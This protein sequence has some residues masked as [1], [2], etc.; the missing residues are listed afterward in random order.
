MGL[1]KS[2][3][4]VRQHGE[5]LTPPSIVKLM[6]DPEDSF[7]AD[8]THTVLEP[9]VGEGVFLLDVLSRRLCGCQDLDSAKIPSDSARSQSIQVLQAVST[10]YG[11][12][13]Q[14]D[15][16][17]T[18]REA[19]IARAQPYCLPQFRWLLQRIVDANIIHDN[20]IEPSSE[21][22][23]YLWQITETEVNWTGFSF[24]SWVFYQEAAE[25][26]DRGGTVFLP[27]SVGYS[28]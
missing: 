14:E 26:V 27:G 8:S 15:N 10:L 1:V 4:R 28:G 5:V 23:I 19:L 17:M 24:G 18:C 25:P 7:Y 9:A 16:C 20:F 11:V 12:D 6:L 22:R 3:D 2:Y 13:I 21:S